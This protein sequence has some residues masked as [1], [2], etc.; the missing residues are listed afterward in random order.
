MSSTTAKAVSS[1]FCTDWRP[2]SNQIECAQG[3]RNVSGHGYA[4][5]VRTQPAQIENQID[6]RGQN[7]SS[8]CA[9]D[10]KRRLLGRGQL[11]SQQFSFDFE[12][13]R[14]KKHGH[15]T[16]IDPIVETQRKLVR[17]DPERQRCFPKMV[18]SFGQRRI[19]NRECGE[20]ET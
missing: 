19:G 15:Q 13:D 11:T 10:W 9:R 12:T 3:K 4:P 7:H 18:V 20:T 1:T 17:T 2:R 5:T 14:E 6:E 8:D 16:V